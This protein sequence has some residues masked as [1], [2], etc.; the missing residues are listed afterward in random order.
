MS[1]AIVIPHAHPAAHRATQDAALHT[2]GIRAISARYPMPGSDV[3]I[4]IDAADLIAALI[5]NV[6]IELRNT[7]AQDGPTVEALL[8]DVADG[9]HMR[10]NPDLY[11]EGASW[12]E[13]DLC[14]ER[15]QEQV[16]AAL[17]ALAQRLWPFTTVNVRLPATV[18]PLFQQ[19]VGSAARGEEGLS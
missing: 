16:D 3:D 10:D 8:M 19:R 7:P 18:V 2:A 15:G 17:A 6:A 14:V 11:A 5:E 13:R 12:R 9:A 4:E 1:D